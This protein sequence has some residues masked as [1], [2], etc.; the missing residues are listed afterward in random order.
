MWIS[1]KDYTALT[2][3]VA[4]LEFQL[5]QRVLPVAA[6]PEVPEPVAVPTTVIPEVVREAVDRMV[7]PY[8]EDRQSQRIRQT[9]LRGARI[10]T[11]LG[12]SDA[13]VIGW[14]HGEDEGATA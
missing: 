12:W 10:R 7:P 14:L 11:K 4:V 9:M 6:A 5:L 1:Q 2:D 13:R 8:L 3:R